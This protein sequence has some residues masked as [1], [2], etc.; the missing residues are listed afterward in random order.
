MTKTIAFTGGKGGTGK[1]T[2]AVALTLELSKKYKV[3]LVDCDVDCPN[4]HLLLNIKRNFLKNVL[5]RI[6]LFNL[7]KCIKCGLCSNVCK[8]NSIVTIKDNFPIFLPN[9]CNG[10]GACNIICPLNA[11]SFENKSVGK[12][13]FND[14]NS[15]HFLGGELKINQP[16]SEFIVNELNKE[17]QKVKDNYDFII[18][19]TAAGTHCPVIAAIKN[20]DEIFAVTE[21]TPFGAHDLEIILKLFRKIKKKGKVILNRSNIGNKKLIESIVQK[22][23]TRIVF[24]V[25]FSK[26]I[27]NFYTKS[28]PIIVPKILSVIK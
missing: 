17:I 27:I 28:K 21:P 11:I 26:K 4:D 18:I 10:C 5:Q 13:Y 20:V 7:N 23:D 15:F 12:I 3:L 16:I 6:P 8:F 14:D 19:D 25:P 22:Y 1:S 9:Q 2:L 24:S